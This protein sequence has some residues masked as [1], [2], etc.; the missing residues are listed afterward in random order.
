[1]AVNVTQKDKTLAA[2]RER[3]EQR[4]AQLLP[5]GLPLVDDFDL[6]YVVALDE[7]IEWCDDM[8]GY[9]GSMP[10][11]VPNQSEKGQR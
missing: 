9:S 1:M 7:V 2:I 5:D 11:E 8:S 10:L 6:G 3:C 4:K